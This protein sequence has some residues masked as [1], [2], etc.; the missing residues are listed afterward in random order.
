MNFYRFI[1]LALIL[2]AI[3]PT[4]QAQKSSNLKQSIVLQMPEGDGSNGAGVAW[5]PKQKKYYA[6]FAG[7]V[8]FPMAVFSTDGERLSS[9][10]LMAGA[11]VRGLWFD[12]KQD[13]IC[14]NTYADGGWFMLILDEKGIPQSS[15][16]IVAEMMQPEDNSVGLMEYGDESIC[17]LQGQE[18]KIYKSKIPDMKE[19]YRLYAGQKTKP[20]FNQEE[21]IEDRSVLSENYN[22]NVAIC[23][24][25]KK[26]E[27]GLLN[28]ADKQIELYDKNT[29]LITQ[30]LHL[31]ED[32]PFYSMFNFA[33]ANGI[34]WLFDKENRKWLGYK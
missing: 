11:D 10:D 28:I 21:D 24:Q 29:G 27:F 8:E 34:Y 16:N 22:G 9:D 4:S 1:I 2:G 5:H 18:L 19:S 23:T 12:P 3:T 6:S 14:G 13:A 20:K 30:I 15:E 17:F 31:P 7:N 26:A 33:Y 32:A 25:Q